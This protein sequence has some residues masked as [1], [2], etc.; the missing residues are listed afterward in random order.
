MTNEF[1]ILLSEQHTRF[2]NESAAWSIQEIVKRVANL[3]NNLAQFWSNVEGW[4][5]TETVALLE[6]AQLDRIASLAKCLERWTTLEHLQD[7]EL[8]LAWTNLGSVLE[9]VLKLFL[10]IYVEDYRA[11]DV[12]R[13]ARTFNVKKQLLQDPDGLKLDPILHYF[14]IGKILPAEQIILAKT[15]QTNRNAI[16]AFKRRE[17][18]QT[19]DFHI[20]LRQFQAMLICIHSRLPYP[21]NYNASGVS[22]GRT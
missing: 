19:F 4:A 5:P 6:N 15:I 8:I 11:D 20:A 22:G 3:T 18:G 16:H 2:L 12:A 13:Q 1:Q 14:E 7:G 17:I 9:G 10:S 21:D